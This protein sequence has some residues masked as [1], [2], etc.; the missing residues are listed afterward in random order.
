[1]RNILLYSFIFLSVNVVF[2]NK[3]TNY[4]YWIDYAFANRIQNVIND[5]D[6]NLNLS[7]SID[8]T[9]LV[10]GI[11]TFNIR[12]KDSLNKWS[13]AQTSFF[14]KPANDSLM[15]NYNYPNNTLTAYE[16]WVDDDFVNRKYGVIN[17][18]TSLLNIDSFFLFEN[19]NSGIHKFVIRFKDN[20]GK[21]SVAQTSYFYHRANDSLMDNYNYPNNTLIAYEYWVDD[22]YIDKKYET[23][24]PNTSI[25]NLDSNFLLENLN[26][27]IHKFVIRFKDNYGKWSISQTSYFYIPDNSEFTDVSYT[28]NKIYGYRYWFDNKPETIFT[29][30]LDNKEETFSEIINL[31]CPELDT[32][33][34]HVLHMQYMDSV[35]KWSVAVSDTFIYEGFEVSKPI[36]KS[37]TDNAN[38]K[39]DTI[40]KWNIIPYI[41][42]YYIQISDTNDFSN[43]LVY[44]SLT[45]ATQ[46]EINFID[47]KTY[48]WRVK[49]EYEGIY[50][51]WSDVWAFTTVDAAQIISLNLGW[52]LIS[53]YVEPEFAALENI[54]SEIEGSTVIVKNNSGQIYYPE[55]DIND[56]GDWDVKQAYQV[57]MSKAEMLTIPGEMV[58]PETTEITLTTGWNM[59]AYLRD[60]A[61]DIENALATLVADDKLVIA[62][63]NMGNVFYPAFEI[64]MIGD[65]LPGQGYQI[66][67]T[68]GATLTY[69]EN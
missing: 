53:T 29:L 33:G 68:S 8:L 46:Y 63:D 10:Q 14:Y 15:D 36:L 11:H 47:L 67:L 61:M 2:A 27:G 9:Y 64:N 39:A 19:I 40:L 59:L 3:I 34:L 24:N 58:V 31:Q 26:S 16:Y 60:N 41:S 4:E 49:A 13:V 37:P 18:N 62:K 51:E 44:D 55:F 56:I 32:L 12:F 25:M 22:N 1:M 43:I 66:Y 38:V 30:I 52:N 5:A 45:N 23:L 6:S 65:M 20:Y 17:P 50:S 42:K 35:G 7:E 54:F 28:S 69:P 57:Y 48:Y 21:W